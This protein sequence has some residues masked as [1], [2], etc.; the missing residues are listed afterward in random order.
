M[1]IKRMDHLCCFKLGHRAS[2]RNICRDVQTWLVSL[3]SS[4]QTKF[5]A[6]A[7]QGVDLLDCS[8]NDCCYDIAG[9]VHE[10]KQS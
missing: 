9:C 5:L 3:S 6:D 8:Y 4:V 10:G 1:G 2:R 7:S